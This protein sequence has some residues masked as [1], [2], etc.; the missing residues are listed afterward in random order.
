LAENTAPITAMPSTPPNSRSALLT[1]EAMPS[2]SRRTEPRTRFAIGAKNIA[3]P[4]PPRTKAGS[5]AA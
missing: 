5:S 2:C 3:M 1:P 4:V